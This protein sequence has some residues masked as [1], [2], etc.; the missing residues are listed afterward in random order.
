MT[1]LF[2]IPNQFLILDP[3][4]SLRTGFEFELNQQIV[5]RSEMHFA[6]HRLEPEF[7]LYI[8]DER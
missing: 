6:M 4:A 7:A 3:S 5:L 8:I 1:C 2:P